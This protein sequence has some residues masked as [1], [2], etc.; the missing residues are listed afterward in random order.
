VSR[1]PKTATLTRNQVTHVKT[2]AKVKEMV[3][4]TRQLSLSHISIAFDF[5]YEKEIFIKNELIPDPHSIQPVA[6][7]VVLVETCRRAK[8]AYHRFVVDLSKPQ[9][10]KA[11]QPLFNLKIPFVGYNLKPAYFCLWQL[12]LP[13]PATV[14]D[15]LVCEQALHLGRYFRRY[16]PNQGTG[17]AARVSA[18]TWSKEQLACHSSLLYACQRHGVP[19]QPPPQAPTTDLSGAFLPVALAAAK[20]YPRQVT[21]ATARGIHDHLVTIEMPFIQTLARLEW[22]GVRVSP[23]KR[24]RILAKCDKAILKLR[25]SLQRQGLSNYRSQEEMRQFFQKEGLLHL[26]RDGTGYA[27]DRDRLK[28]AIADHPAIPLILALRRLEDLRNSELLNSGLVGS[29]GRI[30]PVYDQLVTATGRLNS[31]HPSIMSVDGLLRPVVVPKRGRGIGEVDWSQVEIGIAAA[32]FGDD[33]LVEMFNMG[34]VYAAMA[35]DFFKGDLPKSARTLSTL[36]F[37]KKYPELRGKMKACALGILYGKTPYG[38]A[39]DM[40]CSER[41][42]QELYN[43]FMAMYPHLRQALRKTATAAGVRGYASTV[44]GLH[45]YRGTTGPVEGWEKRWFVNHLIQGTA[46]AIFKMALNRLNKLYKAHDA[47]LIVPL[48]DAVIFEAPLE[49]FEE[50]AKL[51]AKVMRKTLKEVLPALKPRV[52][53]NIVKP[54]CWNKDGKVCGLSQWIRETLKELPL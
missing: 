19:Y 9:L 7:A 12:G 47:Q 28:A 35:Q 2:T 13:A 41:Q 6:L 42:A 16:A 25:K 1:P 11:L 14:W 36:E 33:K 21:D 3:H 30:H 48:H 53:V 44:T 8:T 52:E 38:I 5:T 54:G 37:K 18:K 27:F 46:A 32:V 15:S 34:D 40:K 45:R 39:K 31:H 10:V 24:T 43:G 20:L 51:T 22:T 4:F 50:V 26:F 17:V 49:A 29:D 23:R